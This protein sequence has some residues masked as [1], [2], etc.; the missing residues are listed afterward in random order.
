MK[1]KNTKQSSSPL[2]NIKFYRYKAV[3][4]AALS[5]DGDFSY[6]KFPNPELV[7][8]EYN[9]FKETPKGYWIGYGSIKPGHLRDN[10]HWVSKTAR[11]RFAYPS[12]KEALI[13]FIKKKE[14]QIKLL[15][16]QLTSVE[17]ILHHCYTLAKNL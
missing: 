12:K 1:G 2:P 7:L 6:P 13:G 17:S 14:K 16:Y 15:Q 5:D 4:Y 3:Q 11:K 8:E 10:A 9:L